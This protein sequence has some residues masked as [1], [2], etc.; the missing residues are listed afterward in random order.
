MP[1]KPLWLGRLDS[2]VKELEE[3]PLP[4][5]DSA[6][7]ERVLSISRRRAQQLLKPLIQKTI[8]KSGLA[9]KE[10]VIKHLRGLQ[11][12]QVYDWDQRRRQ[13]LAE[14]LEQARQELPARQTEIP[15]SREQPDL[16]LDSLPEGISLHPG[17]LRIQFNDFEDFAVKLY[18][19][20]Q[21][22]QN[23]LDGFREALGSHK[24]AAAFA[25]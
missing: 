8:G 11:T 22:I 13:R 15:V 23:D 19:L 12:G 5:V 6:L 21:A 10:D 1:D 7:L 25:V 18:K 2:A 4:W 24:P 3:L 20:G 17:E 14:V 9:M 16:K